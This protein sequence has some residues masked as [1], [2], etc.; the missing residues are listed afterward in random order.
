MPPGAPPLGFGG[1]SFRFVAFASGVF[2]FSFACLRVSLPFAFGV[3]AVFVMFCSSSTRVA[4]SLPAGSL[5]GLS[6]L[7]SLDL[8]A[9]TSA[10]PLVAAAARLVLDAADFC[11]DVRS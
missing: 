11:V 8:L 3:L 7:E 1:V 5:A 10:Q 6:G 2:A 9:H 4:D